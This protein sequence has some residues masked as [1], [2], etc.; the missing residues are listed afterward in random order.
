[1]ETGEQES[2]YYS[3]TSSVEMS[4]GRVFYKRAIGEL[5]E[6]ESSKAAGG[7]LHDEVVAG[8][9]ILDAACGAGHYLR[10]MRNMI[11]HPFSYV[12][13]D[14]S[15][16]YV[17]LARQAYDGYDDTEFITGDLYRLPFQDR[18]FDV[19][20]CAN[21]LLHLPSIEMPIR[22]LC[23]VTSRFLLLRTLIGDRS[24]L[25][26]QV[27]EDEDDEG[28]AGDPQ[29]FHNHNIYSSAY[30]KT[31]LSRIPRVASF[32]IVPDRDFDPA[33]IEASISDHQGAPDAT[34]MLNGWQV[35][36]YIL[37]PWAF[38]MVRLTTT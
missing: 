16:S 25:I 8:D 22:E 15:E 13:V 33:R 12:G 18:Q 19:T 7:I 21:V 38:V 20:L 36:G 17:E 34:T 9:R 3:G 23:R 1:M 24:F 27:W 29:R 11:G 2:V 6:M 31:L 14:Q 5:P 10:T 30:V 37:Q 4:Y 32:E 28:G 35:N 26:R